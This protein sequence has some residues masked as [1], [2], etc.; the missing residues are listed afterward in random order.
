MKAVTWKCLTPEQC[1]LFNVPEELKK[2]VGIADYRKVEGGDLYL[3]KPKADYRDEYVEMMIQK[4]G[5][6]VLP[7]QIVQIKSEPNVLDIYD[8]GVAYLVSAPENSQV[9]KMV[10]HLHDFTREEIL[11]PNLIEH[12]FIRNASKLGPFREWKEG[13]TFSIMQFGKEI[14]Y[15]TKSRLDSSRSRPVQDQSC[16][17]IKDTILEAFQH[18]GVDPVSIASPGKCHSFVLRY[19]WNQL[20]HN[21]LI[22]NPVVIHIGSYDYSGDYKPIECEFDRIPRSPVLSIEQ[23]VAIVRKGGIVMTCDPFRNIKIMSEET[24]SLY[25]CLS[26]ASNSPLVE[27][28]TLY[29]QDRAKAE[30]L[31]TMLPKQSSDKIAAFLADLPV[32]LE[33]VVKYIYDCVQLQVLFT[34]KIA[35]EKKEKVNV[36][37]DE[38]VQE[39]QKKKAYI[40]MVRDDKNIKNVMRALT[41]AYYATRSS[42]KTKKGDKYYWGGS[43]QEEEV[44]EKEFIRS[45]IENLRVTDGNVFYCLIRDCLK[46]AKQEEIRKERVAGSNLGSTIAGSLTI[47]TEEEKDK[48]RKK[49]KKEVKQDPKTWIDAVEDAEKEEK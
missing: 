41:T 46:Y 49:G 2:L 16:P 1:K 4:L 34:K 25:Q 37:S 48:M 33:K 7:S 18:A 35:S 14:F 38:D 26:R 44:N 24:A 20:T 47:I 32:N 10:R 42:N 21:E 27:Y 15:S 6:A 17:F 36:D 30:K 22:E 39:E 13:T 8:N 23:A 11:H 5:P 43:Q 3:L 19:K 29:S 28:F 9:V 45:H 40:P 12:Y 31:I